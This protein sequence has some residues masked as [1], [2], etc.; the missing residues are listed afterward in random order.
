MASPPAATSTRSRLLLA[1]AFVGFVSLGLPD[2]VIGVAWPSVRDTFGLHLSSLGLVLVGTGCGYLLSS[3]FAGR[4]IDRL[5]IGVLLAASS[6]MVAASGLGFA[7]APV[8][9]VFVACSLLHGLGSGA[10]DGGLNSF[11]ASNFS[12]RH[13]NW[14]HACYCLGAMLGPMLMTGVLARNG[15]WRVAYAWIG[16]AMLLLS[17][18]F[19][20]TRHRWGLPASGNFGAG[21]PAVSM[22][23]TLR[24]PAVWLQMVLFLFYTGLEVTVGQW[25]FTLFTESRNIDEQVAGAWVSLYWGSIGVGRVLLG[26]VVGRIGIDRLLRWSLGTALVGS[27]LFAIPGPGPLPL[28]GLALIGLALAPIYP[29]LMTRTPQRLGAAYAA[30]AVG[31]QV[32]AAMLGAAVVPGVVGIAADWYGL[33]TVPAAVVLLCCLIL[34]LHEVLLQRTGPAP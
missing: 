10:I 6:T 14:L 24:H 31:F 11:A 23:A 12:A 20:A 22:A 18:L 28:A 7:L 9:P 13:M 32:S 17:L 29:G 3:F 27:L 25:T 26:F 21:R 15:S 8:W 30:H 1:I 34:M 16:T 4:L 19:C 33:E 2:A 5:G